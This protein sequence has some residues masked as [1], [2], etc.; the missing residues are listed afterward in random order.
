MDSLTIKHNRAW[1]WLPLYII[2]WIVL[3]ILLA[4]TEWAGTRIWF[5]RILLLGMTAILAVKTWPKFVQLWAQSAGGF[6]LAMWRILFF[7]LFVSGYFVFGK[8]HVKIDLLSMTHMPDSAR[9]ALPLWGQLTHVIPVSESLS[10]IFIYIMIFSSFFALIGFRTR[11]AL[12]VFSLSTLYVIG[13]TQLF[14]KI[15]HNHYLV[16][17][18]AVL[19]F[20][21]CGDF[22]SVDCWIRNRSMSSC[23]RSRSEKKYGRALAGTWLLIG[24]MYFF[25]GFQK[26][27]QSGLDWVFSNNFSNII[28]HKA[29]ELPGWEPAMHPQDFPLFTILLAGCAIVFEL[30]FIFVIPDPKWRWLGICAGLLFHIGT[31]LMLNIFFQFLFVSYASFINWEKLFR[32]Q[33]AETETVAQSELK[34]LNGVVAFLVVGNLFCGTFNIHSW[35][36]SCYPTFGSMPGNSTTVF[37]FVEIAKDGSSTVIPLEKFHRSFPVE[38][39]RALEL[40]AINLYRSKK[41]DEFKTLVHSLAKDVIS[42]DKLIQ[43]Y[44]VKITWENGKTLLERSEEPVLA[45]K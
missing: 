37:E 43:V 18:P 34:W 17:F 39:F 1:L 9:V 7:S 29:L 28:H 41:H 11:L 26:I 40:R 35:P 19:A 23:F 33:P 4:K 24:I 10:R 31:F 3:D 25:P 5:T 6:N 42:A 22:L 36:L 20:S 32:I 8:E 13:V 16:W 14:G 15:N 12:I 2:A 27:W 21:G 44:L 30:G 45:L 38:R